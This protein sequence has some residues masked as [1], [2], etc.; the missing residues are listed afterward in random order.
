MKI[1]KLFMDG[2]D[3]TSFSMVLAAVS[4]YGPILHLVL[5]FR[6]APC[7]YGPGTSPNHQG[8]FNA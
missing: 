7:H 8:A 4:R 1:I 6:P 2:A 5:Y 3:K